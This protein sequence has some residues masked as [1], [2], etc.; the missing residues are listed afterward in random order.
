MAKRGHTS[1]REFLKESALAGGGFLGLRGLSSAIGRSA[2]T[3]APNQETMRPVALRCEYREDPLGIDALQPRLSW[4]LESTVPGARGQLQAAYEILAASSEE[5]LSSNQ[6]DLWDTGKV[7]SDR[8]TQVAYQ[9]T[10]LISRQRVWWK[11]RVWDRAGT[12][13]SWSE[14]AFWSMGMLSRADWKG[15]WIGL[16]GGEGKPQG[17]MHAHRIWSPGSESGTQY[18]RR[19][20]TVPQDGQF[21][22]VDALLFVV[23][24]GASTL[25]VNGTKIGTPNSYTVQMLG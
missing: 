23:T 11:V 7:E 24:S 8:S 1:R 2:E 14:T 22:V 12:V 15:Q 17:L 21:P 9:G 18:F 3:D 25:Y 5:R 4:L 6:G 20:F 16:D 13:S 19:V 10:A